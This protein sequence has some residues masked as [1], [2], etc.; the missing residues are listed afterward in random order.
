MKIILG[1]LVTI[2]GLGAAV[3]APPAY[4]DPVSC[5]ENGN[6]NTYTTYVPCPR[7]DFL[8]GQ[9]GGGGVHRNPD[10]TD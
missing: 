4:A 10:G 1:N 3:F 8:P 2:L 7:W 9:P 5:P 6:I